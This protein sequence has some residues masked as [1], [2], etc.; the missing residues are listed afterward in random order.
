MKR[1]PAILPGLL[2]LSLLAAALPLAPRGAAY[3]QSDSQKR[4]GKRPRLGDFT[5]PPSQ[6]LAAAAADDAR[7]LERRDPD[8]APGED[9]AD[10]AGYIRRRNEYIARLRG[11]LPGRPFD[12]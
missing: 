1:P 5:P 6:T 9:E 8:L 12:P 7:R 3:G 10:K 4:E 11:Y 2:L